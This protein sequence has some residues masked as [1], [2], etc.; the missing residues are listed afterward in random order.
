[1]LKYYFILKKALDFGVVKIQDKKK[2]TLCF[3]VKDKEALFKV[4]SVLKGIILLKT[5][6]K[7]FK[8]W[9]NAFIKKY[10]HIIAYLYDLNKPSLDYSWFYWFTDVEGC[11]N[12]SMTNT[13]NTAIIGGS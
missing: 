9:L 4:I 3:R 10:K 2:N 5:R 11:F 1:M 8:L 6:K 12:C 7:Q 13:G